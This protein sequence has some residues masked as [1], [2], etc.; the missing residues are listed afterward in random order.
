MKKFIKIVLISLVVLVGIAFAAPFV[1]KGK[2][3]SLIK[4]EINKKVNAKVNF[5]DVDISFF[6]HFP[7]VAVGIDGLEVIGTGGFA[8]DTLVSAKRLDAALNIMSIIR[9]KDM[10]IFSVFAE[11]P[12][13]HSIVN[14]QGVSKWDIIKPDTKA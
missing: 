13:I 1:F 6:R 2:I 14:K 8:E 9:G 5:K 7:K 11:S 10:T 4:E 3:I 12:R